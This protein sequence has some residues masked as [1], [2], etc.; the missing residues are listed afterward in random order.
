MGRMALQ[1]VLKKKLGAQCVD[2]SAFLKDPNS[3]NRVVVNRQIGAADISDIAAR[4]VAWLSNP[5]KELT[6]D[7]MKLLGEPDWDSFYRMDD[8]HL[9]RAFQNINRMYFT[10]KKRGK[11]GEQEAEA[12]EIV[13]ALRERMQVMAN[14]YYDLLDPAAFEKIHS[15]VLEDVLKDPE[16]LEGEESVLYEDNEDNRL[17]DGLLIDYLQHLVAKNKA[18]ENIQQRELEFMLQQNVRE[19]TEELGTLAEAYPE[20]TDEQKRE[21]DQKMN[22][23][24]RVI[25]GCAMLQ[26]Q[27]SEKHLAHD[28]NLLYQTT[29]LAQIQEL[30]KNIPDS[31][32]QEFRSKH[33]DNVL[34]QQLQTGGTLDRNP[35]AQSLLKI[36]DAVE[37]AKERE[38]FDDL[39][40]QLKA[41]GV[42]IFDP[43]SAGMLQIRQ[44]TT[45][46]E[47]IDVPDY[48]TSYKSRRIAL[49]RALAIQKYAMVDMNGDGSYK[50]AFDPNNG[51]ESHSQWLFKNSVNAAT[52][53]DEHVKYLYRMAQ[54]NRL[55]L[56]SIHPDTDKY[57]RDVYLK[58]GTNGEAL[59]TLPMNKMTNTAARE[60]KTYEQYGFSKEEF[61]S[62]KQLDANYGSLE[63]STTSLYYG[64]CTLYSA[65]IDMQKALGNE[66][67]AKRL[68]EEYQQFKKTYSG[69]IAQ[70][71]INADSVRH[72]QWY[73]SE[74]DVQKRA[75]Y[76]SVGKSLPYERTEEEKKMV[77][78]NPVADRS[79][80]YIEEQLLKM[81]GCKDLPEMMRSGLVKEPNGEPIQAENDYEYLKKVY[82]TCFADNMRIIVG[83]K[84]YVYD[85]SGLGFDADTEERTQK[86]WFA[87]LRKQME[88]M[89]YT[90]PMS[91]MMLR[92]HGNANANELTALPTTYEGG[93]RAMQLADECSKPALM[94]ADAQGNLLNPL[95]PNENPAAWAFR[96]MPKSWEN[97]T[98]EQIQYLYRMAKENRLYLQSDESS[99]TKFEKN[100]FISVTGRDTARISKPMD[101]MLAE[102]KANPDAKTVG[103]YDLETFCSIR[104]RD[105]IQ[106]GIEATYDQIL[107]SLETF[108]ADALEK[109][110]KKHPERREYFEAVKQQYFGMRN[111]RVGFR[112]ACANAHTHPDWYKTQADA[113]KMTGMFIT[114]KKLNSTAE[115]RAQHQRIPVASRAFEEVEE[116]LLKAAGCKTLAG[117][118]SGNRVSF[119][120]GA[121]PV[122]RENTLEFMSDITKRMAAGEELYIDKKPYVYV[123]GCGFKKGINKAGYVQELKFLAS[124]LAK[125]EG[126]WTS[127]SPAYDAFSRAAKELPDQVDALKN[128]TDISFEKLRSL[129]QPMQDAANQY[130]QTHRTK[131]LD[132]RQM[133]RVKI[134]NR[135]RDLAK[136]MERESVEPG[137]NLD[138]RIAEK[139]VSA[140]CIQ[141]KRGDLL[142]NDEYRTTCIQNTL[143]DPAFKESM[144]H[145]DEAGKM[146]I[147]KMSGKSAIRL[148][149]N[150]AETAHGEVQA[151]NAPVQPQAHN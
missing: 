63:E 42:E 6:D 99:V 124:R 8:Q 22:E 101:E 23:D 72:P 18:D 117:A 83:D 92:V 139:L 64:T 53:S 143:D 58:V 61:D 76:F 7:E 144:R 74:E 122:N 141:M 50:K 93:I 31:A 149:G 16:L 9:C 38:W 113:E 1:K 3:R 118:I 110:A 41:K 66:D 140:G 133:E 109:E 70:R 57:Q 84:Q 71:E 145:Y 94:P 68:T 69:M 54:E 137:K 89:G 79:M 15:D 55:L 73:R 67:E 19:K 95:Q 60:Q 87:S 45:E 13:E 127:N 91:M 102:L 17:N 115:E 11:L 128:D 52:I 131:P 78:E 129:M 82:Q 151:E 56:K 97:V 47:I 59:I 120:S 138:Y 21:A 90:S 81:T 111:G 146:N 2:L 26:K 30:T 105:N 121:A 88:E 132:S 62:L 134:I 80:I 25:L 112:D 24:Y 39:T 46:D 49:D 14:P 125:T 75:E 32:I 27:T 43:L 86:L 126:N 142:M 130:F 40:L 135:F 100:R 37:T 106:T 51:A 34:L 148:L 28:Q 114:A 147:L 5:I 150:H 36:V 10:M 33:G 98:P 65:E 107:A 103:G 29:G 116:A 104:D 44:D 123:P 48:S 77:Q 35:A 136:E 4:N 108:G 96:N 12:G 85:P 20:M 119:A